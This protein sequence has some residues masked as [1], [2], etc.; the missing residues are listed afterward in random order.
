[1]RLHIKPFATLYNVHVQ[2]K[3]ICQV[4]AKRVAM[5]ARYHNKIKPLDL[6]ISQASSSV[7]IVYYYFILF[8][9]I[10]TAA[11][12]ASVVIIIVIVIDATI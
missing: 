8:Y 10:D 11:T 3:N 1:M 7:C 12:T 5:M 2:W 6:T 4:Y 9:G